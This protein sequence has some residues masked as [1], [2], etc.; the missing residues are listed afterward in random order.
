MVAGLVFR[1]GQLLITQR[2]PGSHL[3]GLWEFPG[4]KVEAGETLEQA[5]RRELREELGIETQPELAL[6]E[7]EHAYPAKTVR[8]VFFKCRLE[9]GEPTGAE[10]QGIRW[11]SRG[12]LS[13]FEFP[14]AD[15][16][17][18]RRLELESELWEEA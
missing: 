13:T 11:V 3:A 4:G 9:S 5:L 6:E 12:E 7:T 10:G 15:E 16:H 8:I 14:S 2:K 17:L 1:S 18:K